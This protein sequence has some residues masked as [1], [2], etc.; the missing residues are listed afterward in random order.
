MAPLAPP[1]YAYGFD[2]IS[3]TTQCIFRGTE[4][5]LTLKST[6][7]PIEQRGWLTSKFQM[8]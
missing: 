8:R 6:Q 7:M 5:R 4:T 2:N 1:G 3:T